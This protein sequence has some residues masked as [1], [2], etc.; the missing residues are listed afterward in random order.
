MRVIHINCPFGYVKD[1]ISVIKPFFDSRE[2]DYF[3]PEIIASMLQKTTFKDTSITALTLFA[4]YNKEVI[5]SFLEEK[6]NYDYFIIVGPISKQI[7][8]D[9]SITI[10]PN[11]VEAQYNILNEK[12]NMSLFVN[13]ADSDSTVSNYE[14]LISELLKC[15]TKMKEKNKLN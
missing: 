2:A 10:F 1:T 13:P 7:D 3:F 15:L 4:A 5:D 6:K 8:I 11:L 12:I 14:L 9:Y